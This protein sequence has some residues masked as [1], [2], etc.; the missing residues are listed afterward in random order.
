MS[1][2]KAILHGKENRKPYRKSKIF[3][4][5]C[6]NHGSCP[7]CRD[8][9][10]HNRYKADEDS[11]LKIKEAEEMEKVESKFNEECQEDCVVHKLVTHNACV[12]C[13]ACRK[14]P[15]LKD[16]LLGKSD[17]E[18]EAIQ[19]EVKEELGEC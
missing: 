13:P 18:I 5:T 17:E 12:F 16:E 7:Y 2:N 14:S 19:K 6:R 8:N 3:D 10:L 15:Y 9:R 11:K 4:K 1:L